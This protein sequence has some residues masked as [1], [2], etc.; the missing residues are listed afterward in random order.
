VNG[1]T[2]DHTDEGP[3]R[4]EVEVPAWVSPYDFLGR[5]SDTS[6]IELFRQRKIEENPNWVS[7]QLN[8][9]G[10]SIIFLDDEVACDELLTMGYTSD[11]IWLDAVW[12]QRLAATSPQGFEQLMN[13][14]IP[15]RPRGRSCRICRECSPQRSEETYFTSDGEV[16]TCTHY[17]CVNTNGEYIRVMTATPQ[18]PP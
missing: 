13:F 11:D 4:P 1:I 9:R 7:P 18:E 3:Q 12:L 17:I 16:M 2:N 14:R 6:R 5:L 15:D 8:P 10:L